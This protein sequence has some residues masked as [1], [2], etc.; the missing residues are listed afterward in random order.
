MGGLRMR[1]ARCQNL[2]SLLANACVVI[3]RGVSDAAGIIASRKLSAAV[4][5]FRLGR[6]CLLPADLR[7]ADRMR[8]SLPPLHSLHTVG[9]RAECTHPT[10]ASGSAENNCRC[11]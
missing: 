6:Q 1:G 5:D 9:R 8:R 10:E 11:C 2:A 7:P 3:A 4:L